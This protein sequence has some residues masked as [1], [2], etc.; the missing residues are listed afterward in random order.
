MKD[1][2]IDLV[3]LLGLGSLTYGCWLVY[4]PSAYIIAGVL[5]LA[6]ACKA[7]PGPKKKKQKKGD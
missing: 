2:F 4:Q 3:G 1:F 5:L 6:Y 7:A